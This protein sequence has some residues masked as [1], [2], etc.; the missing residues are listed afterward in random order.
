MK[1]IFI[2]GLLIL[3]IACGPRSKKESAPRDSLL[4]KLLEHIP[5]EEHE[6][7][8]KLYEEMPAKQRQA[9]ALMAA[10]S[11]PDQPA[12]DK[13]KL[14][15]HVD[16]SYQSMSGLIQLYDN[17]VTKDLTVYVEFK[18]AEVFPIEIGESVDLWAWK[19]N[20]N[21]RPEV[22]FQEW[23]VELSSPKLDSLLSIVHWDRSDLDQIHRALEKANCIS[24]QNGDPTEIGFARRGMRKYSYAIFKNN[25]SKE[26]IMDYNDG[27]TYVFYKDNIVLMHEG[28]AVGPQCF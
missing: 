2:L 19:T 5:V 7:F 10:M 8:K 24:I 23:S 25:L 21:G 11:E 26:K 28:G 15:A 9:L 4:T 14:I 18:A 12:I 20:A 27:C 1:L 6:K 13:D 3:L 22:L 17:L 16:T